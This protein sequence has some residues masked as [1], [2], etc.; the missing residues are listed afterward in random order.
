MPCLLRRRE[1]ARA[2]KPDF[3]LKL[4]LPLDDR[5]LLKMEEEAAAFL[6]EAVARNPPRSTG[7]VDS[8]IVDVSRSYYSYPMGRGSRGPKP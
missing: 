7:P 2:R 4:P 5:T 3:K 8:A 6:R 1:I